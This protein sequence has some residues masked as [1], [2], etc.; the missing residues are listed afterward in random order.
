MGGGIDWICL[1]QDRDKWRPFVNSVMNFL[2]QY[3]IF[4]MSI[5][6]LGPPSPLP[7]IL[8]ISLSS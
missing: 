7:I 5:S 8:R 6:A 1:A 4:T 3:G 2:V